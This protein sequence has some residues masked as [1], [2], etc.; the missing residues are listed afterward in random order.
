MASN[1]LGRLRR[2]NLIMAGLHAVQG[3]AILWLATDFTLPLNLGY[4]RFDAAAQSLVPAAKT[5][6]DVPLAALVVAF[7]FMSALAHLVIATVGRRR[8]ERGLRKGINRFRWV[9]YAFSASTMMVAV[10]MLV[11]IYDA[12][13]LALIFLAVAVMNLCGLVMEAHN[14]ALRRAETTSRTNWLAF[15]VGSL[16]GIAPW[17]AVALYLASGAAYGSK[18]PDFVYWIFV[19]IFVFFNCF[20]INMV[21]QYK[22]V[23]KWRDYLYGERAYILLSLFAKSAL[24]WQVFAGTLRP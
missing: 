16:A 4:L 6:T 23:G 12:A 1:K 11:G 22:G 14:Q 9:E 17:I 10:A 21:L 2:F 8:Y 15:W 24:A 20:A 13:S 7:L 3:I 19:S 5:I 18:A